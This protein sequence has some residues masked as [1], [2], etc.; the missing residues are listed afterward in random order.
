MGLG[1]IYGASPYNLNGYIQDF[2]VT[3]GV[4]RYTADFT[5]SAQPFPTN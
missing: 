3:K 1:A 2:R 4:A 5:P